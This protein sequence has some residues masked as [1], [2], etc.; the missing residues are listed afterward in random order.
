MSLLSKFNESSANDCSVDVDRKA[1]DDEEKRYRQCDG[2]QP[3]LAKK[4]R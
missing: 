2:A 4:R 1:K 3:F